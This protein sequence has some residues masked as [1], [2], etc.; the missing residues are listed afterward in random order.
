[1]KIRLMFF[2]CIVSLV[3]TALV[4]CSGP[5]VR[6][7]S[8]GDNP[9]H[10]YLVG[11]HALENDKF[12]V[13]E[14][15]FERSVYLDESYAKAYAGLA[16]ISAEQA[17][18]QS[19]PGFRQVGV[20]KAFEYLDMAEK[21]AD[22]PDDRFC[23]YAA[24]IRVQTLMKG[25]GW[26]DEAEAAF[27]AGSGLELKEQ[28]LVYYQGTEALSHFMG[29]AYLEG[30]EFRKACD[31]FAAVLSAKRD[32]KWHQKADSSWKKADRIVRA[33]AG[34]T[35]GSIGKKFPSRTL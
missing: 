35:V 31:A 8:P 21:Y 10:H 2:L 4:G 23:C 28:T 13:A 7:T 20:K 16:I 19:D 15:K 34:I 1:M 30:F 14:E 29:V 33:M 26:L 5:Q 25:E 3:F 18:R 9:E 27:S 17:G 32:G 12:A 6:S 22:T 24:R 11:M